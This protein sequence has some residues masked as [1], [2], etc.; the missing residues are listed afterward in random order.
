MQA[1]ANFGFGTLVGIGTEIEPLDDIV[2]LQFLDG[3]CRNR[4]LA[5]DDN[6]SAVGN[7]DR[8]V[9]VLFRHEHGQPKTLLELADLRNRLRHQKWRQPNRWFID[10]KKPW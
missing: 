10:Q 3:S 2:G 7:A 8:L 1:T 5:M 4:D 6:I 9:E